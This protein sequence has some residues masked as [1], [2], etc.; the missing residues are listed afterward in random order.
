MVFLFKRTNKYVEVNVLK[1]SRKYDFISVFIKN[2]SRNQYVSYKN[3]KFT[4]LAIRGSI[5][6]NEDLD[7]C[8]AKR[9][10]ITEIF[11]EI[12]PNRQKIEHVYKNSGDP[13][14]KSM[15]YAFYLDKLPDEGTRIACVDWEE[16][17]R[18][19]NNYLDNLSVV[20][21][22]GEIINWI[23]DYK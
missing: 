23:S 15:N 7:G 6:Y 20:I 5:I 17:F 13:S 8:I 10:E 9:D 14:S 2:N 3:E 22:T 21:E 12:L 4:I 16:T 11:S 1:N 19:K 18:I